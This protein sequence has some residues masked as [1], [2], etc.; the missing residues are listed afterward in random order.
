MALGLV[1]A[2]LADHRRQA[3]HT[4]LPLQDSIQVQAGVIRLAVQG[5]VARLRLDQAA[6]VP[7]GAVGFALDGA[8]VAPNQFG[9]LLPFPGLGLGLVGDAQPLELNLDVSGGAAPSRGRPAAIVLLVAQDV[10]LLDE[11]VR[12]AGRPLPGRA[13]LGVPP[14]VSCRAAA[15]LRGAT[16]QAAL[17]R[18]QRVALARLTGPLAA[19]G[20]LEAA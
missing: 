1:E 12:E 13:A 19:A 9:L 14:A 10:A 11:A 17:V 18:V 6:S 16:A 2:L 3:L 8:E 7:L 5:L 15:A 4:E 20:I